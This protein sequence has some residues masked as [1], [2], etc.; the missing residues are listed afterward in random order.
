MTRVAVTQPQ[1]LQRKSQAPSLFSYTLRI[2]VLMLTFWLWQ[3]SLHMCLTPRARGP[4]FGTDPSNLGATRADAQRGQ[5]CCRWRPSPG[6]MSG[7]V[8]ALAAAMAARRW[9]F[10]ERISSFSSSD[11]H[12]FYL[13]RRSFLFGSLVGTRRSY[14]TS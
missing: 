10:E 12:R 6:G 14:P 1:L 8:T 9:R 4:D 13:M 11:P 7:F 2:S 3:R 5:E